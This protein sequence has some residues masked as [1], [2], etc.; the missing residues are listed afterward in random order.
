MGDTTSIRLRDGRTL[1]WAEA[2]DPAGFPVLAFHGTPGTHH[3][4]LVD[5]GPMR[6]TG[7][8]FIAPDRPG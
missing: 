7:V 2:G 3:Q 1:A 5:D 8:R 4:I 6:A